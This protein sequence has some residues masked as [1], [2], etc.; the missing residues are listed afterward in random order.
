MSILGLIITLAIICGQLVKIPIRGGGATLIDLAVIGVCLIGLY[1]IKFKLKKPPAYILAGLS[2]CLIAIISLI[3]TPL[4]LTTKE[5]SVSIF[6]TLRFS[7]YILLGWLIYSQ[8]LSSLKRDINKILIFSGAGLAVLGLW[9]FI[10]LPDLKFLTPFGWD[11][12]FYRTASSFLDPN[13][14]GAFLVLILLLILQNTLLLKSKV[15][16]LLFTVVYLAL[17]TT[18]SRS[19]YG[20]FLISFFSF[21]FFK[22]S[23]KLVILT[24]I[25]FAT[26]LFSF[27]IYIRSVNKVTPLDRSQTASYRLSTWQ[28][29]LEI[30]KKNPILGV[31][32]NTYS[33]ALKQYKLADQ[34]FLSG[35]GST[36]NDSSLLSVA[37]TTG[38]LGIIT[39]LFFLLTLFFSWKKNIP[40]KS[41]ILGLIVHSF[42]VNSLFYPF[43]LVWLILSASSSANEKPNK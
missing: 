13:F 2:F 38:I 8:V 35:R 26:L 9:Q 15:K 36:G 21:S 19:S 29:G 24:I 41:A 6:Y 40:L 20:M 43:I 12:H 23:F 28:Q 7:S 27:K 37:A 4:S 25:L 32:F 5:Y 10:F 22:K 18:F 39:Y 31:G 30:F 17:M 11:P 16:I 42:F 34:Q 33:F 1:Q 14:L 3:F